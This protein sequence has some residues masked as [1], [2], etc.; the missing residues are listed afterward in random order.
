MFTTV[1]H[2]YKL[3]E[4]SGLICLLIFGK[5]SVE[6]YLEIWYDGDSRVK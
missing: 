6:T 4:V 3:Q 1:S 2:P 5:I